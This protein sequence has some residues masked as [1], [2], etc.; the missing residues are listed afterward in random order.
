MSAHG[1][2]TAGVIGL[3][4]M[5]AG[6]AEV[7]ARSGYR[8]VAREMT[9]ELAERGRAAVE[10]S[11][12]RG[13]ERGKVATAAAEEALDLLSVTTELEALAECDVVIE[14]ATEK[15]EL[16]RELFSTLDG[17]LSS[18]A[19][20]ATN[21]SALSVTAIA[22]ATKTPERVVGT[23]FFNPAQVLEL[24]EVVRTDSV[25]ED[26][27]TATVAFVESLGKR[28]ILCKDTPGFVVNRILIPV[29][30]DAVNVYDAG[31]ASAE[32]VDVAMKLGTSWPLGPLELI[33]LIGI[34]VHVYVSE[35]LW[36][37]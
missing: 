14:A 20:L 34:D 35:A 27:V 11:L 16:K 23:H 10:K 18:S 3:G 31:T 17:L 25:S 22:A 30:N 32:D 1:V 24:V 36:D 28:P 12:T 19:I 15:I 33:D 26:T 21:T 29:L 37:A 7:C 4:T 9:A 8:T 2:R 13:V 5:G 6:I